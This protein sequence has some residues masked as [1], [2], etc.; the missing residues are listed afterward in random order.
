MGRPGRRVGAGAPRPAPQDTDRRVRPGQ[1]GAGAW[2]PE[3]QLRAPGLRPRDCCVP[4]G[5]QHPGPGRAS[6][7]PS[8]C[9]PALMEG[10]RDEGF[11]SVRKC[12]PRASRTQR[13]R[14]SPAPPAPQEGLDL[15]SG[16]LAALPRRS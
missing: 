3:T 1:H 11:L 7:C 10:R 12:T 16:R 6:S 2:Q 14:S 4:G 13:P 15:G 9:H 5:A 8:P